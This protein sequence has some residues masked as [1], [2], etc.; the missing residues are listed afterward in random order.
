MA[1]LSVVKKS[2]LEG[3]MR[4]DAEYYQSKY[5][6]IVAKVKSFPSW[7]ILNDLLVRF[8]SGINCPQAESGSI[9]FIRTQHIGEILIDDIAN[10]TFVRGSLATG[11]LLRQGDLLMGRVG[12]AGRCA[13]SGKYYE[14]H[15]YSDNILRLRVDGSK[16]NPFFAAV[17]LNS[18]FGQ[19]QIERVLKGVAQPLIS[20]DNLKSVYVPIP[21]EKVQEY[22]EDLVEQAYTLKFNSQSLYLQAEQLLLDEIGFKDLDLSHQLYYSV[23]YKKTREVDRLDAEHFQPRYERLI[24]HLAKTGKH[25][26]LHDIL[27][28]PVQKGITP[29][30]DPDGDIVVVNS[31]HLGR[32]C[33]NIESTD[34]TTQV[35]WQRNRRAQ[36]K[37]RDIMVYATGAYIGRTNIWP[38][39]YKAVA[40]VDILLIRPSEACNPYYL[41]VY[42]NSLLGILQ[43]EK[44]A[45]GSGQRHIYPDNISQF[46]VHLPSEE[47]QRHIADLVAQSWEARQKAR[48]LLEE[49]KHK[50]EDLVEGKGI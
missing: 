21:E 42:L 29:E 25:T 16:L 15:F 37:P 31:Q 5:M 48:Q 17:F 47:F 34:R 22:F 1:Q 46:V 18:R 19:L 45:S 30:Y 9:R 33:L 4:L 44:F 20:R 7:C 10:L 49:A 14:G 40:G 2:E 23:S 35:F 26:K 6:D 27:N 11:L 36:V 38:L 50:V 39:D 41:S 28:E 12:A 13:V 43:A 3:T 8:N 24:Q 32:Y